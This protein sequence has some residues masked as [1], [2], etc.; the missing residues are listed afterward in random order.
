MYFIYILY[1]YIQG[2]LHR[3]GL[4]P[5][6]ESVRARNGC[7]RTGMQLEAVSVTVLPRGAL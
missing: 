1:L 4:T 6:S 3:G 7:T 5:A 2:E